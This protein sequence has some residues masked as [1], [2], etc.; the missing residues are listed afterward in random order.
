MPEV[1]ET[2]PEALQPR[3]DAAVAWFNASEEAADVE[4][5][6]RRRSAPGDLAKVQRARL[7]D[8]LREPGQPGVPATRRELEDRASEGV[9]PAGGARADERGAR[10]VPLA[11]GAFGGEHA[12]N[13]RATHG[14]ACVGR[15]S[16][17]SRFAAV[18]ARW[19]LLFAFWAAALVLLPTPLVGLAFAGWVA[20]VAR[21]IR[22]TL[23]GQDVQKELVPEP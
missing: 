22:R 16:R 13:A 3:V 5:R 2:I 4:F 1:S 19:L 20:W 17:S 18:Y 12:G 8:A 15:R 14:N 21:D 23:G 6:E 9:L 10:A 7:A 11:L